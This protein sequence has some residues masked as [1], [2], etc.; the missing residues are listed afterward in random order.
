MRA[1]PAHRQRSVQ[2]ALHVDQQ[3]QQPVGGQARHPEALPATGIG[4][5]LGVFGIEA[6]DLQRHHDR[7]GGNRRQRRVAGFGFLD[8]G[9]HCLSIAVIEF[10]AV[11]SVLPL[12]RFVAGLHHRLVI[13]ADI[14][15][16]VPALLVGH[17][18]PHVIGVIPVGVVLAGM[19]AAGL[20][21][22]E[23]T[24]DGDLGEFEEESQLD[25]LQQV[26][27]VTLALVMHR[28]PRVTLFESVNVGQGLLESLLGT[29]HRGVVVH[30][31]LQIRADVGHP[32][33][34]VLG[35]DARHPVA[36]H[37]GRIRRQ[38]D[39]GVPGRVVGGR[40]PGTAPEH[41]DVEQRVGAQAISPVH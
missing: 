26:A 29:E 14:A 33:V 41:V 13:Q 15:E 32:F 22:I 35:E 40:E 12:H 39:A 6:R 23:R 2:I 20:L 17:G 10:G 31:L 34:A 16:Q 5:S 18:V 1:G 28:D 7:A 9:C 30:R 21:A 27:V 19:A 24:G 4:V 36:D 37:G 25:G 11:I 8:D 38:F 3:V